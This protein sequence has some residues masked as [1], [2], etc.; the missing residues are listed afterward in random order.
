MRVKKNYLTYINIVVYILEFSHIVNNSKQP[1]PQAPYKA[2]AHCWVV[3]QLVPQ[4]ILEG[5]QHWTCHSHLPLSLDPEH[6]YQVVHEVHWH[7]GSCDCLV[8][9]HIF[10]LWQ[11]EASGLMVSLSNIMYIITITH[12]I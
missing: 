9:I 12:L 3:Q 7:F 4:P 2:Q 10:E 1:V 8:Y 5:E 6:T 11:I